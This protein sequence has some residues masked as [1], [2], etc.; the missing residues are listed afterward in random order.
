MPTCKRDVPKDVAHVSFCLPVL[1]AASPFCFVVLACAS[2]HQSQVTQITH[3]RPSCLDSPWLQDAWF[4]LSF[5]KSMILKIL[6][7]PPKPQPHPPFI[8]GD[9][10]CLPHPTEELQAALSL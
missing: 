2:C 4:V 7:I 6:N 9:A 1:Y 5:A 10:D 8:S 3:L